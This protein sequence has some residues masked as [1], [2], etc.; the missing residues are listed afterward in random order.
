M[1]HKT[2]KNYIRHQDKIELIKGYVVIPVVWFLLI[3]F[4]GWIL[5][6]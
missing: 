6:G 5:S 3:K 1:K 4:D 2:R